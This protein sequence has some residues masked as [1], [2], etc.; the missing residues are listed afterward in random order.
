VELNLHSPIRLS[1]IALH[2]GLDDQGSGPGK[3]WEFF[4]SL[5]RLD[6]L[7]GPPSLLFN[8]YRGLFPWG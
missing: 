2:Y 3:G 5:S 8:G 4:S 7:W 6:Q 1:G